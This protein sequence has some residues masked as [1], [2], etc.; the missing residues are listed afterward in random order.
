MT[1]MRI[2]AVTSFPCFGATCSVRLTG[3]EAE[4][5]RA[6]AEAET[7]LLQWHAAFSRFLPD[8]ELSQLNADPRE[9]VPAGPV[10]LDLADAITAAGTLSGG[11]VDATLLSQIGAAGYDRHFSGDGL[12]VA[13]ALRLA[14]PRRAA[15][16]HR[17]SGWRRI[18]VDRRAGTI[19]RPPGVGLDSGGIAKGLFAD[20]IAARLATFDAF[21]VDCGGDIRLGGRAGAEREVRIT[22]PFDSSVIHRL[23]LA[24]GAVATSG[25]GKRSWLDGDG[26]PAHHLLDPATGRPAYTG[27][28]QVTAVAATAVLAETLAKAALLSG[29]GHATRWLSRGGVI[30]YDDGSAHVVDGR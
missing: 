28:V 4:A 30:V 10:M 13:D 19:S 24:D 8:S 9:T 27:I 18:H 22:S 16:P 3:P 21:A 5:A 7:Q 12:P 29:P 6:V 14:P 2:E 17:D 20:L 26:R 1:M 25:I 11:L 23:A 15:A